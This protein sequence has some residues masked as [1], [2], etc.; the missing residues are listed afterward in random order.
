[1]ASGGDGGDGGDQ[2]VAKAVA[3]PKASGKAAVGLT[4]GGKVKKA[5]RVKDPNKPKRGANPFALFVQ[6][7]R[8]KVVEE[9]PSMGFG[10]VGKEIGR[11]WNLLTPEAKAPYVQQS[12]DDK[13]RA[14]EAADAYVA[15]DPAVLKARRAAVKNVT[16]S[17]SPALRQLLGAPETMSRFDVM[18]DIHAY[19]K[20]QGLKDPLD[21]RFVVANEPLKQLFGLDRFLAISVTKLLKPHVQSTGGPV[22][23]R[24]GEAAPHEEEEEEEEETEGAG[25]VQDPGQEPGP[26]AAD[27]SESDS[28]D[29]DSL[30]SSS[31]S[32]E[33]E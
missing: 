6:A 1:V 18:R 19:F 29:D 9:H 8:P 31:S 32:S 12:K 10:D 30:S 5:N 26:A 3:K 22:Q 20:D 27:A 21:K 15:P 33:E 28:S 25:A 11:R 17:L 14:A 13:A 4:A 23:P 7:V 2:P 24:A 16:L